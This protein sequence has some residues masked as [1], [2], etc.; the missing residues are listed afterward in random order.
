MAIRQRQNSTGEKEETQHQ[1]QAKPALQGP[2]AQPGAGLPSL[3][4]RGVTRPGRLTPGSVQRLQRAFGNRTV[5]G[6]ISRPRRIG[7]A[8]A[9]VIQRDIWRIDKPGESKKSLQ[10]TT[11]VAKALGEKKNKL[12]TKVGRGKVITDVLKLSTVDT[13]QDL[14]ILGH[15]TGTTVGG[16]TASSI[17]STL[18]CLLP[19]SFAGNIKLISCFSASAFEHQGARSLS[20]NAITPFAQDLSQR[21]AKK[22]APR[23]DIVVTGMDGVADVNDAGEVVVYKVEDFVDWAIAKTTTTEPT[24]KR[25]KGTGARIRYKNGK[26]YTETTDKTPYAGTKLGVGAEEWKT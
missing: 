19:T 1:S 13:S 2:L 15:G 23:P 3:V 25:G 20:T 5:S 10:V 24:P 4:Q 26:L 8:Q 12:G 17:A 21:L 11:K 18:K 6:L 9:G 22:P 7:R 16:K 14:Y